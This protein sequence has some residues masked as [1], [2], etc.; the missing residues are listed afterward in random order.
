MQFFINT[1]RIRVS[2]VSQLNK[3]NNAFAGVNLQFKILKF[4]V[5]GDDREMYLDRV[6]HAD[7]QFYHA[8]KQSLQGDC[9]LTFWSLSFYQIFPLMIDIICG[10]HTSYKSDIGRG[11]DTSGWYAPK[12]PGSTQMYYSAFSLVVHL[13]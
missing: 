9:R 5:H 3:I 4:L 12:E 8:I 13:C 1:Y 6:A 10:S 7:N 2:V 11:F